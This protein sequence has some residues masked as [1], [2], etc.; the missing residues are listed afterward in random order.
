MKT[1][2]QLFLFFAL[3]VG[4]ISAQ[5]DSPAITV[6]SIVLPEDKPF[7][8]VEKMPFFPGGQ[9]AMYNYIYSNMQYPPEAK[10]NNMGGQVVTQFVVSAEGKITKAKIVR[11]I[12]YGCDEEALRLVNSM[13]S[14]IP[15]DYNGRPVP[16]TFTLPIKFALNK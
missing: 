8:Y 2:L 14:W 7:T 12:G 6:D 16:V 3:Y 10:Q 5:Q 1:V 15:G 11:S 13:P 4:S 9:A